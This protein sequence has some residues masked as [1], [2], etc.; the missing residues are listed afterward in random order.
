MR[1][2][3]R[4]TLPVQDWVDAHEAGSLPTPAPALW[5]PWLQTLRDSIFEFISMP[6]ALGSGCRGLADKAGR[7]TQAWYFESAAQTDLDLVAASYVSHT[8]LALSVRPFQTKKRNP[9]CSDLA[10]ATPDP[11]SRATTNTIS[12]PTKSSAD[13]R[14]FRTFTRLLSQP[15]TF[16]WQ[17]T[18]A[19]SCPWQGSLSQSAVHCYRLGWTQLGSCRMICVLRPSRLTWRMLMAC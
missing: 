3:F 1:A 7:A 17:V 13:L 16:L 11:T 2:A 14:H 19:W 9:A 18:W 8:S 6:C 10:P 4:L 5:R 12:P 15:F